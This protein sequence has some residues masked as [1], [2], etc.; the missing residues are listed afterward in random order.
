MKMKL[1][2]K[3]VKI[4]DFKNIQEEADFW[5]T[6]SVAPYWNDWKPVK[7]KVAKNLSSGITI[8]FDPSVLKQVRN[9]AQQKGIGPTTLIRM[10]VMEKVHAAA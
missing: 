7:V 3:K 6:H 4:P 9:Q 5:D 1:I 8:R 10:W 2:N